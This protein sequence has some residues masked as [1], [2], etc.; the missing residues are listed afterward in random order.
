MSKFTTSGYN[1]I[2][3]YQKIFILAF[4][5][6]LSLP[7][8]L[9]APY[10]KFNVQYIFDTEKRNI[11][12]FPKLIKKRYIN[13]DFS[14]DFEK[15][16]QDHIIFREQAINFYQYIF[17]HDTEQ[18]L[19]GK[20]GFLFYKLENSINNYKRDIILTDQDIEKKLSSIINFANELKNENIKFYFLIG[21]DKHNIYNEYFSNKIHRVNNPSVFDQILDYVQKNNLSSLLNIID[22]RAD[23]IKAKTDH[24]ELYY[25]TDTHWNSIG[26]F[27]S[28]KKLMMTIQR[29]FP[30]LKRILNFDDY[31]IE[32]SEFI[33]DMAN[34]LSRSDLKSNYYKFLP[35]FRNSVVLNFP[36]EKTLISIN[37]DPLLN[38]N[39]MIYRDSFFTVLQQFVSPYFNKTISIHGDIHQRLESIIKEKPDLVIYEIVERKLN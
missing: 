16:L 39:V 30:A 37:N 28:H 23:L 18:V 33:G 35:K 31:H 20:N 24:P 27:V 3:F 5:T 7:V 38:K 17:Q 34:M 12:K 32:K 10:Y 36:D 15:W 21:P 9:L 13:T 14:Q 19:F 1:K 25:K 6:F 2:T 8:I 29:D 4:L 11:N 22:P 26:A